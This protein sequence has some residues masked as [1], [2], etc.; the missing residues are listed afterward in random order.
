METKADVDMSD[1]RVS[2]LVTLQRNVAVHSLTHGNTYLTFP[3]PIVLIKNWAYVRNLTYSK[4]RYV[5]L[6]MHC[7]FNMLDTF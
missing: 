1:R 2:R 6:T 3:I 7:A 5:T 4:R